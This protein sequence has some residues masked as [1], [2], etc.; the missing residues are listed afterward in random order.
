MR[1]RNRFLPASAFVL[2]ALWHSASWAS[3]TQAFVYDELGR[4]V[5]VSSTGTVNNG[6]KHSICYD[7]AGNRTQYKSDSAG[8]GITCTGAPL[9]IL[10]V[11]NAT[12]TE[13]VALAF[14][15]T[16]SGNVAPAVGA[17]YTTSQ[18]TAVPGSDYNTASGTISFAA[19]QTSATINVTT[20]NDTT[21]ESVETMTLSLSSPTGGA[22]FGNAAATGTISDNDLANLA[23]ANASATEGG[24]LAFTITR[25]G[26]TSNAVSASYSSAGVTATSGSDFNAATGTVS[27]ASNQTTSTINVSTIDDPT[28][29]P[30]ETMTV[31]LSNPSS[32]AAIASAT[33]TGTIS[34][35]DSGAPSY[36]A[37]SDAGALEGFTLTFTVTRTGSTAT[38]TSVNYATATGT[39]AAN[40][41]TAVSGT[42]TFAAGQQSKTVAVTST[43]DIRVESDEVLYLNLSGATGGTTITDSQG[44]GTIYDDGDEGGGGGGGCPLC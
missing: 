9:P 25:S 7:A 26:L 5:S 38:A 10:N 35:N 23:I 21:P 19:N 33:G 4:L 24:M 31:S 18:G 1:D 15:V 16:R 42:L 12:A 3:E 39:A 40:D 2:A 14:V 13:G 34:D 11:A 41:F 37:I 43:G 17:S 27:F 8:V 32:G 20:I 6:Q 22:S 44:A 36:L 29:E 30:S 28:A